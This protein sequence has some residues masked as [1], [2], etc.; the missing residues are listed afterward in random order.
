MEY[1]IVWYVDKI[2]LKVLLNSKATAVGQLS[3]VQFNKT[4]WKK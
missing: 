2:F 4:F 3:K 1:I